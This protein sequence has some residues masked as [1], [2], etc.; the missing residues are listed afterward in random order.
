[1]LLASATDTY[2]FETI[3][4][5]RRGTSMPAFAV[6]SPVRRTLADDDAEALVTHIRGFE[7]DPHE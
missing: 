6:P 1:V 3:R 2:L 5:G 4:R 7:V